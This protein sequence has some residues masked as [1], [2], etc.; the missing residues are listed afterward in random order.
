MRLGALIGLALI[1]TGGMYDMA[2]PQASPP[3]IKVLD[4][5]SAGGS[6][7]PPLGR[8]PVG[9][10]GA[11]PTRPGVF[12]ILI[13]APGTCS[14]PA[15]ASGILTSIS[16]SQRC[17]SSAACGIV[18]TGATGISAA[19]KVETMWSTV[20]SSHHFATATLRGSSCPTR[21]V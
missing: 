15:S 16:R 3:A 20:F 8:E 7:Q 6:V 2:S 9:E 10:L 12:D 18:F 4:D 19:S 5:G 13:D 21:L 17:G 14:S 1:A 11:G